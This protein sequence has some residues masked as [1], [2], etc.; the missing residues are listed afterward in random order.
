MLFTLGGTAFIKN[1]GVIKPF[2]EVSKNAIVGTFISNDTVSGKHIYDSLIN[3][4]ES[5]TDFLF[6]IKMNSINS[7]AIYYTSNTLFDKNFIK[8]REFSQ[9]D[10]DARSNTVIVSDNI[11][12]KCVMKNGTRYFEYNGDYYEVIGVYSAVDNKKDKTLDCYF[13]YYAKNL[14]PVVYKDFVFDAGFN[15]VDIFNELI[16]N[17]AELEDNN[18]EISFVKLDSIKGTEFEDTMTNFA[19]M[20]IM[21]IITA[22]LVLLNSVSVSINWLEWYKKEIAIRKLSGASKK[23]IN[24]WI[25]RNMLVFILIAF[26]LGVI[27]SKIFLVISTCLP[28]AHSVQLMFGRNINLSG[29]LIGFSFVAILCGSIIAITIRHYNHKSIKESLSCADY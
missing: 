27:M 24:L 19:S 15:S 29:A 17:T 10:F 6:A 12:K 8:G 5:N 2:Q 7:V 25:I 16:N 20:Q 28:V 21:L 18:C 13:N 26:F 1:I 9:N 11:E 22:T 3:G 4:N 23:D 14:D